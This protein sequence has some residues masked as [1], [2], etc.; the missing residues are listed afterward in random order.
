MKLILLIDDN[1]DILENLSE[2]LRL[3][4]YHILTADNEKKGIVQASE[5]L[6]ELV[7]CAMPWRNI[8]VHTDFTLLIN[9]MTGLG[10]PF[11]LSST[12]SEVISRSK[13]LQLGA[14]GYIIKP[15]ELDNMLQIIKTSMR[16]GN[17][18]QKCSV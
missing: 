12:E 5:F 3:E 11:I 17:K 7:I 10:I 4:G 9:A 14:E 18:K 15:F 16:T 13:A 1:V 8:D 2:Y 6:P